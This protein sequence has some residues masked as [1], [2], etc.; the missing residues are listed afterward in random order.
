MDL[1]QKKEYKN[2]TKKQWKKL[3]KFLEENGY[4]EWEK[5][6]KKEEENKEK[7]EQFNKSKNTEIL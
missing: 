7:Y 1:E 4:L 6:I 2:I 5:K 3:R